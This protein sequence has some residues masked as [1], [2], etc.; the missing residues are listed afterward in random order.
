MSSNKLFQLNYTHSVAASLAVSRPRTDAF[1][2]Q[3]FHL[4]RG[5]R[6]TGKTW[7]HQRVARSGIWKVKINN[8]NDDSDCARTYAYTLFYLPTISIT[9]SIQP[10]CH[11]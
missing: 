10:V 4:P 11:V 3:D 1:P 8:T 9:R 6:A 2:D 5:V 7:Q